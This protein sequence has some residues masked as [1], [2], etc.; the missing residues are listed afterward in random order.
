MKG[1]VKRNTSPPTGGTYGKPIVA[2]SPTSVEEVSSPGVRKRLRVLIT[3]LAFIPRKLKSSD[4]S[5]VADP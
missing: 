4:R 2:A 3:T 5:T 1:A